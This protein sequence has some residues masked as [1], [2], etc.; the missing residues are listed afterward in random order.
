MLHLASLIAEINRHISTTYG[1]RNRSQGDAKRVS[2]VSQ[3]T[4]VFSPTTVPIYYSLI[5]RENAMNGMH[6]RYNDMRC[7]ISHTMSPYVDT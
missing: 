5:R 4:S 2:P 3:A 6:A 1:S 7:D